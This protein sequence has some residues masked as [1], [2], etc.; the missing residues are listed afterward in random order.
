MPLIVHRQEWQGPVFGATRPRFPN[1]A[2]VWVAADGTPHVYDAAHPMRWSER[3]RPRFRWRYEVDLSRHNRSVELRNT[4]LPAKGDHYHFRAFVDVACGVTDPAAVVRDSVYDGRSVIYGYLVN[5]FRPVTRR[6]RI[7]DVADAEAEINALFLGGSR[8][9]SSGL[10]IFACNARLALD[11]AA[12]AYLQGLE[13]AHRKF[14]LDGAEHKVTLQATKQDNELKELTQ[15]GSIRRTGRELAETAG[16]EV[17]LRSVV[18]LHLAKHPEDTMKMLEVLQ[19]AEREEGQHTDGRD[20]R[21]IELIRMLIDNNLIHEVDLERLNSTGMGRLQAV[22]GPESHALPVSTEWNQPPLRAGND[23]P[24]VIEHVDVTSS[25]EWVQEVGI[26]PVYLVLDESTALGSHVDDLNAGLAKLFVALAADAHFGGIRLGVFSYSDRV[27]ARFALG[28]VAGGTRPPVLTGGGPA[29]YGDVFDALLACVP[30]D[31]DRLKT[32]SG[33][34]HR[35][36]VFFLGAG[37]PSDSDAWAGPYGRLVDRATQP[38]APNIVAYAIG[39]ADRSAIA[40]IATQPQ[41]A[42]SA[43]AGLATSAGIDAFHLSVENAIVE[44][45]RPVVAGR[46]EL[47]IRGSDGFE[48][49]GGPS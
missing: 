9:I 11:G 7:E 43:P 20:S 31:V 12:R 44:L 15:A 4:P 17:N 46:P 40:R 6:H 33:K 49:I 38:Y 41:Y 5:A 23:P 25:Q 47:H 27:T 21:T 18:Q 45:T 30:A 29:R 26:L 14:A 10:E 16:R 19:D 39:D 34:V 3:F 1:A 28:T 42:R 13:T 2:V 24:A 8:K 48:V 32:E 37:R 35:P 36:V 22:T